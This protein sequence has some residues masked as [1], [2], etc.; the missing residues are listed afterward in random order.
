MNVILKKVFIFFKIIFICCLL[1]IIGVLFIRITSFLQNLLKININNFNNNDSVLFH[2]L[3]FTPYIIYFIIR[4]NEIKYENIISLK[5]ILQNLTILLKYFII[6][7]IVLFIPF[8]ILKMFNLIDIKFVLPTLNKLI[9]QKVIYILFQFFTFCLVAF[10]E[11]LLFRGIIL[12]RFLKAFKLISSIIISSLIFSFCHPLFL[13]YIFT[14]ANIKLYFKNIIIEDIL[15]SYISIFIMGVILSLLKI[16]TKSIYASIGYHFGYN[17]FLVILFFNY[18]SNISLNSIILIPIFRFI[19]HFNYPDHIY[20]FK[21]QINTPSFVA[22][23]IFLS[24]ILYLIFIL[25][26]IILKKRKRLVSTK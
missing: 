26:K 12:N 16:K 2:I 9:K 24:Q 4:K 6:V 15:L 19:L 5:P 21:F 25:M 18:V 3:F 11:E 8:L 17:F 20:I 10:V 13:K 22:L 7:F 1:Y 23:I 14:D